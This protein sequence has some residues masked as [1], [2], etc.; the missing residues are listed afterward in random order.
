MVLKQL[1]NSFAQRNALAHGFAE[2]VPRLG[3]A[4]LF[5]FSLCE[6]RKHKHWR[7]SWRHFAPKTAPM[8]ELRSEYR[9][10]KGEP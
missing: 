7:G 4:R 5:S 8:L 3:Y 10:Y 6:F 9:Q 2:L 1:R